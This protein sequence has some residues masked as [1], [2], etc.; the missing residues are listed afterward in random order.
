[1]LLSEM[2]RKIR[3]E[4][5]LFVDTNTYTQNYPTDWVTK[6]SKN[7]QLDEPAI[8]YF[9]FELFYQT[10]PYTGTRARG[11]ARVLLGG[12][13]LCSTG[14]QGHGPD[15]GAQG[16]VTRAGYIYLGSGSYTFDFQLSGF[17]FNDG[18]IR[19]QGV[20]LRRLNFSDVAGTRVNSGWVWA[21]N[22]A[23]T[24]ILN[25]NITLPSRGTVVGNLKQIPVQFLF[26]MEQDNW[27]SSILQN[28]GESTVSGKLNWRL[29]INDVH[30]AWNDR[31]G[32]FESGQTD[33]QS[34]SEGA[35]GL[36]K[37]ERTAGETINVKVKVYNAI[38]GGASVRAI[39]TPFICPW[40]IPDT[41]YQ[42]LSLSFPQGSTLYITLEPLSSDPTKTLKLGKRRAWSFGDATDY[43][44][45]ASGT[46]IL[47][48]NYTFEVVEVSNCLLLI[49]GSG[50]C[51]SVIA[52]D[53][54]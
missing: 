20:Q 31:R 8:I 24:T 3:S 35:Y 29:Y 46:G 51:I 37:A 15:G 39:L 12:V 25:Q 11:N 40:I 44:S 2:V 6:V 48:W 30:T 23:E 28:P 18:Y 32:D 19:L 42:P 5:E 16:T 38:G 43:Y 41:E 21:P 36:Y 52:V 50:G 7:I 10:Q 34:Y 1:M 14:E 13:P 27:R 45:T 33:Y 9:K 54:R 17:T 49:G 47:Y 53:V 4:E 22:N 26:Y